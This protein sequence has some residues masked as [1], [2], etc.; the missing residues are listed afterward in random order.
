[1]T[2]TYLKPTPL[3]AQH[4]EAISN[5]EITTRQ[6]PL[7]RCDLQ[8][9]NLYFKTSSETRVVEICDIIATTCEYSLTVNG[10]KFPPFER[11]EFLLY[12]EEGTVIITLDIELLLPSVNEAL[13]RSPWPFSVWAQS[14]DSRQFKDDKL[15]FSLPRFTSR[16][17]SAEHFERLL[18]PMVDTELNIIQIFAQVLA[19]HFWREPADNE[20]EVTY[21]ADGQPFTIS[22]GRYLPEISA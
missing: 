12:S 6:L 22:G 19:S 4:K 11:T 5:P 20:F 8:P 2:A 9:Q 13:E 14:R 17:P 10:R 18:D 3:F 21:G 16:T 1:M 7:A 15:L